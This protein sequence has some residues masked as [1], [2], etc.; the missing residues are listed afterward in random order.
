MCRMAHSGE[1]CVLTVTFFPYQERQVFIIKTRG[2][3]TTEKR[4]ES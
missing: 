4:I 1:F 2:S 3:R